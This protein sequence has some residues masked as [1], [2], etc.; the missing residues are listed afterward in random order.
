[1]KLRLNPAGLLWRHDCLSVR[2]WLMISESKHGRA[3]A[4]PQ[5]RCKATQRLNCI[6]E[7]EIFGRALGR[8]R[9]GRGATGN[10]QY[11][12]GS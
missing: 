1:M 4:D 11:A 6:D 2:L 7:P 9:G 8:P 5:S 12:P 3:E 10:W